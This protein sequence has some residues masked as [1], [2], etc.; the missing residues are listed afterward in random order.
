MKS[1]EQQIVLVGDLLQI[2]EVHTIYYAIY[3]VHL[4]AKCRRYP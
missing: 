2:T 3:S 1:G 4:A